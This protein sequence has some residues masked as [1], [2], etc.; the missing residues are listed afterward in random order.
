MYGDN[1][2]KL[3]NIISFFVSVALIAVVIINKDYLVDNVRKVIFSNREVVLDEANI[4][5]KDYEFKY[6][7]QTYDFMP[8]S[9]DD[10]VNIFYT[11]LNNG[12]KEFTF[13]CDVDYEDCLEDVSSLSYDEKFLAEMN[14][15]V[16]PYNGYTTIRTTYDD[17]GEVTIKI[18]KLYSNDEIAKIDQDIDNLMNEYL[19]DSMTMEE[20][21]KKMHDVIINNT[22]YDE[23]R[24]N[25]NQSDYDSARITGL[26]YEHYAICSGYTD[27]MAVILS[28]LDVKNFKVASNNHVWNALQLDGKWYHLDLTWDDPLTSSGRDVLY[29]TYFL[30][31]DTELTKLNMKESLGEHT[32]N[33]DIYLEFRN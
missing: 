30:V 13:Y 18:D 8:E 33:R 24:A 16:H 3:K 6:F 27:T 9:Y 7:H 26:L 29:H 22:K 4:W 11:T 10:V 1:M 32:Y 5:K 31:D 28:K 15:Y 14:N 12:W 20:K 17:T 19:T 23:V 25:T 2:I 21:I